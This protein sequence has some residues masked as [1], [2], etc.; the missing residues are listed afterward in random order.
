MVFKNIDNKAPKKSINGACENSLEATGCLY[1]L[2]KTGIKNVN[3]AIIGH[4]NFNSLPK[5]FDDLKAVC[6]E[7]LDILIITETKLDNAFPI[8]HFHI[9]G[10]SKS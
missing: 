7:M 9:D 4:L 3:N 10:Y 5:I 8:S 1:V 6:T 2:E